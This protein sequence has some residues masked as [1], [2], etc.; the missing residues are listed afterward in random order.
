MSK[1]QCR[2]GV[3]RIGPRAGVISQHT[4]LQAI[5]SALPLCEQAFEA[6]P[7]V[8]GAVNQNVAGRQASARGWIFSLL[9][10]LIFTPI[11]QG[12]L[13]CAEMAKEVYV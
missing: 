5:R 4:S 9:P 7:V 13:H 10:L 2:M 3:L 8:C 6:I 1:A 11:G 12:S